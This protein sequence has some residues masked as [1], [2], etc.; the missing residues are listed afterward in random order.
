MRVV[1][2]YLPTHRD[3]DLDVRRALAL[4]KFTAGGRHFDGIALDIEGLDLEDVAE[5]NRRLIEL[6]GRLD[7]AAGTIPIGAIVY[8]PVAFDVLNPAL[9]P[10]FPWKQIAPHTDVWLPMAYW[11]YRDA[12]T[13]Y[14]DAYRYTAENIQRLRGHVGAKAPVHVIG[15][16]GD[17][18]TADD[19]AGMQRAAR[20]ERAI[21]TSVYDFNTMEPS[22][23]PLLRTTSSC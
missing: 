20:D 10:E 13:Q 16:I 5:R 19:Y 8:P 1:A 7:R 2:W 22:A 17:L 11:T 3:H 14:R 15:G 6:M 18:A 12:G 4:V 21:G 9:W 23:W